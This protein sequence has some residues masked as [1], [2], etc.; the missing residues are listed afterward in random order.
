VGVELELDD[1]RRRGGR[2]GAGSGEGD[3][4]AARGRRSSTSSSSTSDLAFLLLHFYFSSVYFPERSQVLEHLL[5]DRLRGGRGHPGLLAELEG[6]AG[7]GVVGDWCRRGLG[8][9]FKKKR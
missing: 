3:G 4:G 2:G 8:L 7:G 9:G 6:E 1:P 5:L